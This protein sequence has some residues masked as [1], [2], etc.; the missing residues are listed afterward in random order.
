MSNA[1]IHVDMDAFYASVEQNDNPKLKGK[2]VIVGA[3]PSGR[4]VVSTCSY[5]ARKFGVRS[6]MPI[7]TA[8]KLCPQG[9][10]LPVDM[11]KYELISSNIREIFLKYS[12]LVE[13]IALDEAFIDV[14]HSTKIWGTPREI[15]KQ[16]QQEIFKETGLTCSVGLSFNMFLAKLASDLKKPN[17]FFE[18]SQENFKK[19]VW[20][21]PVNKLWGVGPKTKKQ[22]DL[23]NLKTIGDVAV[24]PANLLEDK[25]GKLGRQLHSLANGIDFRKVE[26]NNIIK[27]IG[28]E[29]TF[30]E[31][32]SDYNYIKQII[33]KL[34]EVIGI[35][36]RKNKL[37]GK[38]V[39]VKI[40]YGDFRTITRSYT[41]PS[42]LAN[43][44]EIFK[45]AKDLF[46]NNWSGEPIR[47][48][49]IYMAG[50]V[51][52]EE[53]QLTLFKDEKEDKIS[54]IMDKI[55]EKHGYN[56]IKRGYGNASSLGDKGVIK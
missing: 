14:T 52:Y 23:Y 29:T 11:P 53:E 44:N 19:I 54:E 33:R 34:A 30:N 12:P 45:I 31:D 27:S 24:Q 17:G 8:H 50:L 3:D 49:G 15:A 9:V 55:R 13:P 28:K 20:P 6:G 25:F 40:R 42:L 21:L 1:I 2:P 7:S 46:N 4:G 22:L 47:L 41:S 32:V 38:V 51:D 5:E 18:I 48:I 56:I 36:L 16:I 43:D 37:K 35:R 39:T 10:F 26:P